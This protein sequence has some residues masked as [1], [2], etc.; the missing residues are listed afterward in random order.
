MLCFYM[1]IQVRKWQTV[2]LTINLRCPYFDRDKPMFTIIWKTKTKAD[3]WTE[4]LGKV[5]TL[6]GCNLLI[7]HSTHLAVYIQKKHF[8][9][10]SEL[11]MFSFLLSFS[12][13]PA[14]NSPAVK[15]PTLSVVHLPHLVFWYLE[16]SSKT[17]TNAKKRAGLQFRHKGLANEHAAQTE[18]TC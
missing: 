10:S 2:E 12:K 16:L 13:Y 6:M 7:Y 17:R 14:T 4:Q 15:E 5:T 11:V 3:N 1:E 18:K 8:E 9:V